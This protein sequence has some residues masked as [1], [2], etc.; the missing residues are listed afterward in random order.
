VV[1]G[2]SGSEGKTI[3]V[4]EDHPDIRRFFG[5]QLQ[6]RGYRVLEA[7]NEAELLDH[8]RKT[9]VDLITL[10]LIMPGMNGYDILGVIR[11]EPPLRN[12]PV[13]ILSMVED[14]ERGI[15]LG[16][17]DYLRKPFKADELIQTIRK[18]FGDDTRSV[19]VV[20]DE[21]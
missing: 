16:A 4:F 3:L 12:I 15:L 10:D 8:G 13:L 5:C 9:G 11:E 18:Y 19:L 1:A 14:K 20:D 2:I 21:P 6:R 17:N 7:S